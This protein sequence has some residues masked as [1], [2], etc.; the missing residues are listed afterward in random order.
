M[1]DLYVSPSGNDHWT[2]RLAEPNAGHTDGPFTTL[3][4]ARDELRLHPAPGATIWLRG[5]YVLTESFMLDAR[6]SGMPGQPVVYRSMPG[7]QARLLGGKRVTNFR[8]V[9]DASVLSRLDPEARLHVVEAD[10]PEL[11]ITDFGQFRSRGLVRSMS[12][13][14]LE[15]FFKGRPMTVAR[16]PNEGEMAG[17]DSAPGF[18]R[19]AGWPEGAGHDDEHGREIGSLTGGFFYD[20]DRPGR[21]ATLDNVWLHGYWAWD[22]ANSYEAVESID[23]ERRLI[24]TKPPHGSWGFRTGNR[25]Y[26]LNVLEELDQ[27][28]EFYVDRQTGKLYFWP[29]EPLEGAEALVSILESPVVWMKN[30]SHVALQDVAVEAGRG[31]GVQIEG[32]AGNKVERCV[33][34]NVGNHAVQ[35]DGGMGHTVSG[36]EMYGTGDGGVFVSGGDRKTLQSCD[37]LIH[38]NHIHHLSRWS[39]CYTPA[40]HASGV[41]IRMTHNLIHDLPHSGII[42]WGNEMRIE[43]NDIHHVTLESGDAGAV[44]TGRDFTARGN[45]IRYNYIHDTGGY[46][47]GTMA[48]YLDDCVSG[49]T[50]YGNVFARVQRAAFIGGGRDNVVENNIF[51]DCKPAVWVDARGLD[52]KVVWHNMVYKTMKERLDAMNHHQPPYSE[53]YPELQQLDAYYAKDDGVPPEGNVIA[54]NICVGGAWIETSWHKDAASYLTVVDNLVGV[55]PCF[56]DPAHDDYRLRDDSPA[57]ALGFKPIPVEQI[58]MER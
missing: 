53:R 47:W 54:R 18:T 7:E 17:L 37:H 1:T 8:P 56:V 34:R 51:V 11:G 58:G 29:P 12:P 6:D 16:W 30:A 4:R 5:D 20:S 43:Y 36:C 52:Q 14:H 41:G 49:E 24:K 31:M 40:I 10:L 19:I 39:R 44:Y 33:L 25:F 48:V 50:V 2:G 21:W 9:S 57:F 42:F 3:E 28:G 45:L 15:L 46:D 55:D 26:F 38:N 23:V 32:G 35:V 27:P 22:W 13:A